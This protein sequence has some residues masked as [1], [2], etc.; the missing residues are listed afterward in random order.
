MLFGAT[1]SKHI[2][3]VRVISVQ[4]ELSGSFWEIATRRGTEDVRQ[5]G[6]FRDK[7]PVRYSQDIA[8]S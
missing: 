4:R 5:V 6:K 2:D 3:G 8:H 7:L 1:L